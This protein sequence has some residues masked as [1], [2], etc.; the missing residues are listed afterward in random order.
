MTSKLIPANPS[1]VTVVRRV[2]QNIT[3]LSAPFAR[4]GHMKVG[5]RGTLGETRLYH[6]I[7]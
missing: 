2:T 7:S 4:F 6:S 1:E 3:T 5:G